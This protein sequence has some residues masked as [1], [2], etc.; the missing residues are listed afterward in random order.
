MEDTNPRAHKLIVVGLGHKEETV[1][2]SMVFDH[3]RLSV[4]TSPIAPVLIVSRESPELELMESDLPFIDMP[5]HVDTDLGLHRFAE[6]EAAAKSVGIS[7]VHLASTAQEMAHALSGFRPDKLIDIS[8]RLQAQ[9]LEIDQLKALAYKYDPKLPDV[10][11]PGKKK[12]R[13]HNHALDRVICKPG[14][15]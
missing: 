15:C 6:F 11:Q 2:F 10:V 13:G 5:V 8:S 4:Y 7:I 1:H 3:G 12:K 14:Y 9:R